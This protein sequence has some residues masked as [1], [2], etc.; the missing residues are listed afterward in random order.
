ML[1]FSC[2]IGMSGSVVYAHGGDPN[3]IHSCVNLA[4]GVLRI[5]A[6][7]GSCRQG[8]GTLDWNTAGPSGPQGAPGKPGT[9]GPAGPAFPITCPPDSV[10]TDTTCVDKYEASVW[11]TTDGS[12]IQRIRD[13]SVTLEDLTVAGAI[14]LGLSA[15]D[16]V[17]AGCPET[18]NG[19]TDFYAVSIPGVIPA[20]NLTWF[21]TTAVARNAGKR[22]A[23]NAEWQAAALGT[24]DGTPCVVSG[25]S[26]GMTGTSGCVSNAGAF[27]MVGNVWEWVA[28]WIPLSV[29]CVPSLF[30]TGDENC[31]GG[32]SGT[33]GPSALVRGGTSI[34]TGPG[35]GGSGTGAGVFAVKGILI[36]ETD[37]SFGFRAAR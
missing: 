29:A 21:Q 27:D 35:S 37:V 4:S 31:L 34:I 26:F 5:V 10:L 6:P 8:E 32:A 11:Q 14:Q 18:G 15:G 7:N 12:L 3:I 16:L 30:E 25:G 2:W 19:C 23:T 20:H 17:A 9:P 33:F 13:G 24:P 36:S 22:L 28:D 1:F